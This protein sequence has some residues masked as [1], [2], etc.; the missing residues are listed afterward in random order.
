MIETIFM[1]KIIG[2][3]TPTAVHTTLD[4]AVGRASAIARETK[5]PVVILGT[6]AVVTPLLPPNQ[7][8]EVEVRMLP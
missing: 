3:G 8:I 2:G 6:V 5:L 7:E 1:N 4:S